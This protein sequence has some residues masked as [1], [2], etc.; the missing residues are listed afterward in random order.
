MKIRKGLIFREFYLNRKKIRLSLIIYA[1]L[2]VLGFLVSLSAK[3]GNISKI[4][5]PD[6][7]VIIKPTA[8]YF[9]TILNPLMLTYLFERTESVTA[10]IKSRWLNFAATSP[11]TAAERSAAFCISLLISFIAALLLSIVNLLIF[12]AIDGRGFDLFTFE[13]ILVIYFMS[14]ASYAMQCIHSYWKKNAT[15][16]TLVGVIV[17]Y[18]MNGAILVA[19]LR[20]IKSLPDKL[21]F[22]PAGEDA[23]ANAAKLVMELV[24]SDAE[25]VLNVLGIIMPFATI[26]LF[27]AV[28][29]LMKKAFERKG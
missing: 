13:I 20:Y 21:G 23:P 17:L 6:A 4:T 11:A 7:L 22:D 26:A 2:I 1:V 29:I 25:K 3:V 16:G 10:D 15:R 27:I 5:D 14:A 19:A 24:R 9:F 8:F 28:F 18:S 12:G